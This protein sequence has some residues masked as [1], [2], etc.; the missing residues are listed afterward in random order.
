[1]VEAADPGVRLAGTHQGV[2]VEVLAQ[3]DVDAADALAHRGGQRTLDRHLVATDGLEHVVRHRLTVLLDDAETRVVHLP[4]DVDAGGVDGTSRRLA[5]LGTDPVTGN[6]RDG[7]GRHAG[8]L[9]NPM[10]CTR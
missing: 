3:G 2:E 1:M 6:Q 5:D 7:V 4:L 10:A 9:P 8:S